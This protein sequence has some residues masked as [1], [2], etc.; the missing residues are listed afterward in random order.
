MPNF[1]HYIHK[2]EF[3]RNEPRFPQSNFGD[4]PLEPRKGLFRCESTLTSIVSVLSHLDYNNRPTQYCVGKQCL[5]VLRIISNTNTLGCIR[6]IFGC[7]NVVI[8]M[9][10]TGIQS[11]NQCRKISFNFP[12]ILPS[13][14]NCSD[15]EKNVS[16]HQTSCILLC[17]RPLLQPLHTSNGYLDLFYTHCIHQITGFVANKLAVSRRLLWRL[18]KQCNK[19]MQQ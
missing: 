8:L 13:T 19:I 12:D 17:I 1:V 3:L 7:K 16:R 14:R 18:K 9:A 11:R 15:S 4:L 10:L 2:K 6:F 5:I